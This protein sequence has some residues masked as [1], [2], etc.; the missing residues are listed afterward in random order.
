MRTKIAYILALVC[1]IN[2]YGQEFINGTIITKRYDTITDVKIKKLNDIKSLLHIVYIDAEGNEQRPD[3][4]TIK[5][6]NRGN[7][8]FTR[9][10]NSGEMILVKQLVAGKKLNLYHRN[11]SGVNVYY[12]E[13]IYDEL[14]KVPASSGKFK[15]VMSEFLKDAPQISKK[16]KEKQLVN[17]E[18]VVSMYNES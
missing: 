9:I 13:K 3:I 16:I 6:Y 15:K 11:Y 1:T 5:C 14:I 4:N 2:F 7:E 18:E 17:I 10:Y 12:V 8:T